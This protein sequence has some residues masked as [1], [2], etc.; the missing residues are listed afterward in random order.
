AARPKTRQSLISRLRQTP[1]RLRRAACRAPTVWRSTTSFCGSR[2]ILAMKPATAGCCGTKI[3]QD[4]RAA[5][6]SRAYSNIT[7]GKCFSHDRHGCQLIVTHRHD[8]AAHVPA[9]S[10]ADVHRV[11]PGV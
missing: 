3:D 9:G 10:S 6:R 2:I 8:A 11:L 7:P 1:A 4:A 5:A